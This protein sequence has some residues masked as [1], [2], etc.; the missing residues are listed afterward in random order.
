MVIEDDPFEVKLAYNYA[1]MSDEH[2][3][4]VKRRQALEQRRLIKEQHLEKEALEILAERESI[5]YLQRSKLI[6]NRFKQIN[7]SQQ[8]NQ[9]QS[10]VI[11]TELF[12]FIIEN[13]DMYALCDGEWH[14]R[15]KCFEMLKKMDPCSPIPTVPP[16]SLTGNPAHHYQILWCRYINFSVEELRFSFRDYTQPLLRLNK[17]HYFGHFAGAEYQPAPRAVRDVKINLGT[18]YESGCFNIQRNMSPFKLYH[19][20]CSKINFFSLAYGPCWEGENIFQ[21]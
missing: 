9:A 15:E 3:E 16:N 11:R 5:I 18:D 10:R 8:S 14:G 13:L 7:S 4:S 6:Y 19:D 20:L 1:L 2:S 17:A 21:Y 12:S